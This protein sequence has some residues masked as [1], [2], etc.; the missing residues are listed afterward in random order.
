MVRQSLSTF[1]KLC[2]W[3]RILLLLQWKWQQPAR[4][5]CLTYLL[6]EERIELCVRLELSF[7]RPLS[8]SICAVYTICTT[9]KRFCHGTLP[10]PADSDTASILAWYTLYNILVYSLKEYGI[11]LLATSSDWFCHGTLPPPPLADDDTP[12]DVRQL[13]KRQLAVWFSSFPLGL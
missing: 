9:S 8:P 5:A 2:F 1:R 7:S 3:F 4:L 13:W 10:P 11:F 6:Q 12:E